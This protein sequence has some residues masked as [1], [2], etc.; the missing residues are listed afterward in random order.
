MKKVKELDFFKNIRQVREYQF[1]V[2]YFFDGLVI[3][4]I[5]EGETFGWSMAKK[6]IDAA[7]E[8]LGRDQPIAYI[9][10]R[11][12]NYSVVPT[13]WLKFYKH[14]HELEFY[15]V[16]SYNQSGLASLVLEKMFYRKNIRQFS[17]LESAIKWSLD[18]VNNE[19][20]NLSSQME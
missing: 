4:E 5:N 20:L 8:L 17:D 12:N 19:R 7:Y 14:R 16:V 15:S 6:V 1:G 2:F 13:D 3:S 10:N 18:Q 11:I 9:S